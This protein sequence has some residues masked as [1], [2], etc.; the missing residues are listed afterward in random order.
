[1]E[2]WEEEAWC[3]NNLLP[4]DAIKI[5]FQET[6]SWPVFNTVVRFSCA[7]CPVRVECLWYGIKT[8]SGVADNQAGVYGGLVPKQRRWI[9]QNPQ[10]TCVCKDPR[11]R[12]FVHVQ[13]PFSQATTRTVKLMSEAIT[14]KQLMTKENRVATE[15][16]T[17]IKRIKKIVAGPDRKIATLIF[18]PSS[19]PVEISVTDPNGEQHST[20]LGTGS[21]ITTYGKAV[22]KPESVPTVLRITPVDLLTKKERRGQAK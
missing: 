5:F 9:K 14:R 2:D 17:L 21:V 8:D 13:P 12:C 7:R 10:H 6:K 3:K 15:T 4:E 19:P 22:V 16:L 11:S 18:N 20:V 1:M